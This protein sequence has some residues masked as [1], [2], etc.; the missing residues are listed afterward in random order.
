MFFFNIVKNNKSEI[1]PARLFPVCQICLFV[2]GGLETAGTPRMIRV[3]R[4][5]PSFHS[6]YDDI[7][8]AIA[9][10]AAEH[11]MFA[12]RAFF[13]I[14]GT[15]TTVQRTFRVNSNIGRRGAVPGCDTVLR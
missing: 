5:D 1:L 11:R 15:V 12:S 13:K 6:V 7:L 10:S 2:Q 14:C 3:V 4:N 8:V 9:Q